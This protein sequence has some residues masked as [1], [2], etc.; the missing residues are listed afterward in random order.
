MAIRRKDELLSVMARYVRISLA[1]AINSLVD[2]KPAL[3]TARSI[4]RRGRPLVNAR[5]TESGGYKPVRSMA[6]ATLRNRGG[7]RHN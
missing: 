5:P 6:V 1:A 3:I 2:L 7:K 4:V